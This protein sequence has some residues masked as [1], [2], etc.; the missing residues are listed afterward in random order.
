LNPGDYTVKVVPISGPE[1]EEKIKIEADKVTI[2]KVK[3]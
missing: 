1:H 3:S 2:I